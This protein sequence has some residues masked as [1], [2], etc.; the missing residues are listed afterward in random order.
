MRQFPV[1]ANNAQEQGIAALDSRSAAHFG[2]G[3]AAGVLGVSPVLVILAALGYK[4]AIEVARRGEA[5][6]TR[7]QPGE[8][9]LNQITDV[10]LTVAGV[11]TGAVVR[12]A[13]TAPAA[14]TGIGALGCAGG[15]KC[16]GKCGQH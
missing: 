9:C 10:L 11:Y 3:T 6:L 8:S 15:C 12:S 2:I 4:A 14:P 5:G 1:V 7:R 13:T 16:G